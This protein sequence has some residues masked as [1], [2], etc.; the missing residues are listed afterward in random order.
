MLR[1]GKDIA[2]GTTIRTQVCIVGSGQ[3]GITAAWCLQR[4]GAK[5]LA[6][7]TESG[8]EQIRPVS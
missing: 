6:A 7:T 5:A 8:S 3:A 4:A 1:N 2:S